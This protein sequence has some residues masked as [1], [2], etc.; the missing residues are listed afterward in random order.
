VKKRLRTASRLVN[1]IAT[2]CVV[3]WR[4]FWLTMI[5][6]HQPEA[7]PTLG[8]TQLELQ[9]LDRLAPDRTASAQPHTLSHYIVKI[10]RLGGYLAR[11]RDPAPGNTVMWRGLARLTDIAIGYSLG[12]E[13]VGN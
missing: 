13:N 6:R 4:I 5:N 7:S 12:T 11:A 9:L 8:L 3:A 1:L 10:A 2:C